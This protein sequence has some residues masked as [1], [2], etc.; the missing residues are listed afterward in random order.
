[1]KI[2]VLPTTLSGKIST[3]MY[4]LFL[5]LMVLEGRL[6]ENPQYAIALITMVAVIIVAAATGLIAIVRSKERSIIILLMIPLGVFHLIGVVF[7]IISY[8]NP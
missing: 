2:T 7:M 3:V 6:S 4:V 8:L 1:M 5:V